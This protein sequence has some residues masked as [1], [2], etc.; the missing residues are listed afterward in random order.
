MYVQY[1]LYQSKICWFYDIIKTEHTFYFLGGG[2]ILHKEGSSFYSRI[3]GKLL[4]DGSITKQ[5][6][7]KPRFQFIHRIEDKEWAT[8]CYKQLRSFIPLNSPK[9]KKVI[10]SR[11]KAGF[12]ESFYV[13]SRTCEIIT[14]LESIWYKDRIKQLPI[15]FI[16]LYLNAE[17]LAWWYQDD[18]NLKQ[19]NGIP[20]KI[21]LSTD[22]FLPEENQILINLL[23][24][25]FLLHFSLDGQNRLILYDQFQILY[26]LRLVEPYIH[27]SM[28]RKQI[29]HSQP[30]QLAK[31]TTIYLPSEFHIQKP[32]SE[33]NSK[34]VK[35][36]SLL[37]Y[38]TERKG[39]LYFYRKHYKQLN[40]KSDTKGY[41]IIIRENFRDQL[42]QIRFIT[43]LSNSKIIEWCFRGVNLEVLG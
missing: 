16:N 21:I 26:F 36:K 22:N 14:F 2:F 29:V 19:D 20:R 11:V 35:L 40:D 41:R 3:T 24:Q 23:K 13:Q 10:D 7:R 31:T 15:E 5:Q 42:S 17:A 39:H 1:P 9:Y 18:G 27:S 37:N 12:T 28:K 34:L 43:G 4:G 25:K 6:R 33:I 32:T 8:H 30:K 38:V